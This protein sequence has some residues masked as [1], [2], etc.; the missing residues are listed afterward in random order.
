[1]ETSARSECLQMTRSALEAKLFEWATV[2]KDCSKRCREPSSVVEEPYKNIYAS[3]ETVVPIQRNLE[4]LVQ[5]ETGKENHISV[6]KFRLNFAL[7]HATSCLAK[8]YEQS[9]EFGISEGFHRT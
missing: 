8:W 5:I 1:M 7:I 9:E 4:D 3:I 6:L 2:L